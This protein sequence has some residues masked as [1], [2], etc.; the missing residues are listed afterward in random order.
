MRQPVSVAESEWMTGD[1]AA[2]SI[3]V[4]GSRVRW[5]IMN[6]HLTPASRPDGTR[7]VTLASVQAE[8]QWRRNATLAA[9][10]RRVL[11]YAFFWSP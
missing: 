9:R 4:P 8:V 10:L 2:K 7:G 11:G 3:G 1:E 6:G 5:L